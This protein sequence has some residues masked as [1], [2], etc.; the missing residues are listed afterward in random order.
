[1][2]DGG[3]ICI[4]AIDCRWD[5]T[6]QRTTPT[7]HVTWRRWSRCCFFLAFLATKGIWQNSTRKYG[8]SK[9]QCNS[10]SI[11]LHLLVVKMI[12]F[13]MLRISFLCPFYIHLKVL[14]SQV[15]QSGFFWGRGAWT[16]WVG[17]Q[18]VMIVTVIVFT[19]YFVFGYMRVE[20]HYWIQ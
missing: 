3:G 18:S 1:M 8:T 20:R 6:F 5:N 17:S 15:C 10:H 19:P 9:L 16:S 7:V 11:W 12:S 4:D 2:I 14:H 13:G